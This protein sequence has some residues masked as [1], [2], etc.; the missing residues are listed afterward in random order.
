MSWLVA[1]IHRLMI[2][3]GV[4]TMS[5]IYALVAPEASLRANFGEAL[6]G[7][8]ADVVV[9]SW[10]ALIATVGAMLIYGALNPAVRSMTLVVASVSKTI[11]SALVLSHGGL[12]LR[13]QA[14]I[15]AGIDLLWVAIFASYL[16][17][18]RRMP[19]GNVNVRSTIGTA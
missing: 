1:N 8:V 12:F 15:A 5:M 19:T 14:G 10:G 13:Y 11:F 2:V 16:L 9:R 17:A 4:L 3:A 7:P 18:V 6:S